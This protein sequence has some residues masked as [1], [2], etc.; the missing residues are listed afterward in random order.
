MDQFFN[1]LLKEAL[2]TSEMLSAG[3]EQ[4]GKANF[5]QKGLYFQAF[6]SLSTGLERL[7]KIIFIMDYIIT[8]NGNLPNEEYMKKEL[9]HDLKVIYLKIKDIQIKYNF[10]LNGLQNLEEKY[11]KKILN[12]LSRFGKGDRYSNIDLLINKRNY[13]DPINSWFNEIDMGLFNDKIKKS[14][15]ERIKNESK[16]LNIIMSEIS[17][18]VHTREDENKID[19]IYEHNFQSQ[20]YYSI[21]KYRRICVYQ[22][23]RFFVEIL[24]G[25]QNYIQQNNLFNIPHFN[26]TFSIYFWDEKYISRRKTL[27]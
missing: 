1:A 14:K 12:I 5:T 25:L 8:N 7:G 15:K 6:T 27:V 10:K 17:M 21:E 23:S 11:C 19:T 4:I 24:F 16:F 18:V 3:Y 2:F 22:I 9:G 20:V 13:I 26:E